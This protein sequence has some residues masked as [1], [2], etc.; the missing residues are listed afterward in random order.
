VPQDIIEA[1]RWL[2]LAVPHFSGDERAAYAKELENVAKKMTPAQVTE[3]E[4][5]ARAWNDAYEARV[6]RSAGDPAKSEVA[7]ANV[8]R[9]VERGEMAAPT[10][11][12]SGAS[13][14]TVTVV[15]NPA[16]EADIR[17]IARVWRDAKI[18][19]D[20]P[21]LGRLMTADFVE[22]NQNGDRLTREQILSLYKSAD[23]EFASIELLDLKIEPVPGGVR[24]SGTHIERVKYRGRD[25]GGTLKFDEFYVNRGDG[26]QLLSSRLSR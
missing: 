5:R 22:I 20:L 3:A 1:Y 8:H 23:L 6:G 11:R 19:H 26:W 24:A 14:T 16:I 4:Q 15:L 12:N 9:E 13:G 2:A 18:R 7:D 17:R 25:V 21:Q 10:S